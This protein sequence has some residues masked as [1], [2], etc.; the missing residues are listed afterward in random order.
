ML[1]RKTGGAVWRCRQVRVLVVV[2][3]MKGFTWTHKRE[4]HPY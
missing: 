4:E 3:G 2:I 1:G